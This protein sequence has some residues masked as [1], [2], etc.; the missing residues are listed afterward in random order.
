MTYQHRHN[1][2]HNERDSK[3]IGSCK[4]CQ[5]ELRFNV[6]VSDRM[7]LDCHCEPV[8]KAGLN[9]RLIR[10]SKSQT[11]KEYLDRIG[12]LTSNIDPEKH[13]NPVDRKRKLQ[14]S[15]VGQAKQPKASNQEE[16]QH[17]HQSISDTILQSDSSP[18]QPSNKIYLK[19]NNTNHKMKNN[20]VYDELELYIVPENCHLPTSFNHNESQFIPFDSFIVKNLKNIL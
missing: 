15:S 19:L 14:H 7:P 6:A 2:N 18:Q 12:V 16:I 1:S 13:P 3:S 10:T 20:L 17:Q 8:E 9:Y 11:A 5:K 4:K